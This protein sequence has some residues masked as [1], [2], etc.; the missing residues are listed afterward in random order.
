MAKAVAM[1]CR[2]VLA[3]KSIRQPGDEPG[4]QNVLEHQVRGVGAEYQAPAFKQKGSGK[5]L[6]VH[7]SASDNELSSVV[8]AG[9]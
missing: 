6:S 5:L 4:G 9:R 3:A 2:I 7:R 1:I 8:S